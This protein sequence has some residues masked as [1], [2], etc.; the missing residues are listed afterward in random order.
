VYP[1]G[2]KI[3]EEDTV[4]KIGYLEEHNSRGLCIRRKDAIKNRLDEKCGDRLAG[5]NDDHQAHCQKQAEAVR[6]YETEKALNLTHYVCRR[7]GGK[8]S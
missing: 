4:M 7:Y 2:K 6:L 8:T 1:V 3:L 5:P